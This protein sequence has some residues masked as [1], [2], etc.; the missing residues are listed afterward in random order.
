MSA[1]VCK[2]QSFADAKAVCTAQ[3]HA[4]ANGSGIIDSR[5][6][7][8]SAL[9]GGVLFVAVCVVATKSA[10]GFAVLQRT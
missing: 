4:A 6:A 1:R 5:E 3:F 10:D 8:V 7:K 9:A 2:T